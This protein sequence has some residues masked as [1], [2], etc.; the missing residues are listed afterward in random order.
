MSLMF[1]PIKYL[2]IKVKLKKKL[3]KK[4]PEKKIHL[5]KKQDDVFFT[6]KFYCSAKDTVMI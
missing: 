4:M 1:F 5:Y 6:S 3:R 2:E